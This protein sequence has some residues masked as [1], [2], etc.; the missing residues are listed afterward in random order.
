[1]NYEHD[2]EKVTDY[3]THWLINDCIKS[4]KR[5]LYFSIS[6]RYFC[7]AGCHVCY[8]RDNLKT[9][10]S[11]LGN[12]F[13]DITERHEEQWEDVFSYFDY[14]RTDDDMM[15]LK[16]N[17]PKHYDY[18]KRNGYKF[19]YGMTDNVIF[20]YKS[21]VKELKFKG[22]SSISLSSYFIKK[23]NGAKLKTTLSE[24][25]SIS[26]IQ[27][28]KLIDCGDSDV[29]KYYSDW[30]NDKGIEVLFHYDFM[31]GSRNLLTKDWSQ[32]QITWM[33]SDNEGN[34]QIY[35]DE[36]IGLFYDRFYFSNENA[37]DITIE[38][39]YVLEETGGFDNKKF[40][41]NMARGKQELYNRWAKRTINDRFRDYFNATQGYKFN[42]E[43]N[44]IPW[45]MMVPFSKYCRNMEEQGWVKTKHGFYF[46][47]GKEIKSFVE[48]ISR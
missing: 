22:I 14:L 15:F 9:M 34:M 26:P 2:F 39:Y 28:L 37:T 41:V 35:G 20:R 18:F 10:K 43:Y 12:Y 25:H 6:S 33:D 16:L 42:D 17:Y 11:N 46:P 40:L 30:A 5:D 38:P 1:M 3:D 36:A 48:K 29:L 47:D 45:Q 23:V 21:Y 44:F 13:Y 4:V 8:I 31:S 24:L 32:N 19:E 7:D 27:Q